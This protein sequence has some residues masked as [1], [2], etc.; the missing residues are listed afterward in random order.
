M[1][2][3]KA[4]AERYKGQFSGNTEGI[5]NLA[6]SVKRTGTALDKIQAEF[7]VAGQLTDKD[8]STLLDAMTIL[9]KLGSAADLAKSDVKHHAAEK[10]KLQERLMTESKAAVDANFK[11]FDQV[12]DAMAFVAW[13][14]KLA[15]T[16]HRSWRGDI[17]QEMIFD[18]WRH[19]YNLPHVMSEVKSQVNAVL[20]ALRYGVAREAEESG[21]PVAEI[22]AEAL[23]DFNAN[24]S[25]LLE[26][27]KQFI[28][29][30]KAA[31]VAQALDRANKK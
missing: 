1:M 29:E 3:Q 19:R 17:R 28:Q 11:D 27:Q 26:Q 20:D 4:L 8:R 23:G 12:E 16:F 21:R 24:R 18:E 2:E 6:A 5:T 13:E 22:V 30:I 25:V 10:Q 15:R 31:A 9:R 7:Y 14:H